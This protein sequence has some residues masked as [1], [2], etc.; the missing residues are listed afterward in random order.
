MLKHIL[1]N[2]SEVEAILQLDGAKT[3]QQI[4]SLENPS[5]SSTSSVADNTAEERLTSKGSDS[6]R[7]SVNQCQLVGTGAVTKNHNHQG[8]LQDFPASIPYLDT[9]ASQAAGLADKQQ[10]VKVG[11]ANDGGRVGGG[12]KVERSGINP[13]EIL[14]MKMLLSKQLVDCLITLV[15]EVSLL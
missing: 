4:T 11:V 12:D 10:G 5:S 7:V 9:L 1:E 6:S 13:E 2:L 15:S 8:R 14:S 3:V